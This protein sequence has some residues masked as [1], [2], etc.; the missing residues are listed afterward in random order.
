MRQVPI[1]AAV[2]LAIGGCGHPSDAR[3]IDRFYEHR[4]ELEQLVSMFV[5]DRGLYRV[6]ET[7]TRP[8][9][10]SSVGVT[11]DRV[12][13]YR[14]LC[15]RVG[16][17][18]CVEGYDVDAS[19]APEA[20]DPIWIGVSDRGLLSIT[21]DSKG[22]L[23]SMAPRFEIVPNLENVSLGPS[24]KSKTWIRPIEGPWYLYFDVTN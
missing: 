4:A 6:G 19:R 1:C 9:D 24:E 13:E 21:S 18:R 2:L 7:F 22:F 12:R 11:P 23:H 3:L 10:P 15:D 16:A 8:E 20:K 14:R 5:A 17:R